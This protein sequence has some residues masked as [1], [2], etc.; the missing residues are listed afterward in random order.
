MTKK[1]YLFCLLGIFCTSLN[2]VAQDSLGFFSGI[3][4]YYHFSG[5]GNCSFRPPK[6]PVLTAAVNT[7][8]YDTA[9]L[10]GACLLVIGSKDSVVVRVEDRCPGCKYGGLDLSKEAF[11]RIDD[12]KKGRIKIRWKQVPCPT[13]DSMHIYIRKSSGIGWFSFIVL[14]HQH[15]IKKVEWL[16]DSTWTNVPR[17]KHNYFNID[18]PGT[19]IISLKLTDCYDSSVVVDSLHFSAGTYID[20]HTQ[21]PPQQPRDT[22]KLPLHE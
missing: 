13:K 4:S 7:A 12:I 11:E 15:A 10:C 16:N 18:K 5:R 3:A 9:A 17:F 20:L 19:A 21:F 1:L 22:T 6:K 2:A 14:N 8:Q